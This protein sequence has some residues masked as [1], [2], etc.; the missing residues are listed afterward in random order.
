MPTYKYSSCGLATIKLSPKEC[1]FFKRHIT[2][3]RTSPA[4]GES[5]RVRDCPNLRRTV[6]L[7]LT[8]KVLRHG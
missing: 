7:H 1:R 4:T 2:S 3:L 5:A 8:E 6:S